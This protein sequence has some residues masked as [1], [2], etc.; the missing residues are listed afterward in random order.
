MFSIV[1]F[2]H[3]H[4]WLLRLFTVSENT[5]VTKIVPRVC[6]GKNVPTVSCV[7]NSY[8]QTLLFD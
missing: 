3:L 1:H 8:M 4:V 2:H 7:S 5:Q 6:I